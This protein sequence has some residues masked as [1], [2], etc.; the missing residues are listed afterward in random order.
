MQAKMWYGEFKNAIEARQLQDM[1]NDKLERSKAK[2][3]CTS[4]SR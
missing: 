4:M 1:C 2:E 3:K